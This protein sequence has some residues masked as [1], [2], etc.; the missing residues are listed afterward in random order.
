MTS[1]QAKLKDKRPVNRSIEGFNSEKKK[2][3]VPNRDVEGKARKNI[4]TG[5]C[6]TENS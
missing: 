6:R 4:I 3:K 1:I 2:T 5:Y